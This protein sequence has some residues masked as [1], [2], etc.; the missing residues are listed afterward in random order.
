MSL[1]LDKPYKFGTCRNIKAMAHVGLHEERISCIDWVEQKKSALAQLL[2]LFPSNDTVHALEAIPSHPRPCPILRTPSDKEV[3]R[4]RSELQE[5][6]ETILALVSALG[7]VLSNFK[8]ILAS[9]PV[10]D[11]SETIAEAERALSNAAESGFV[12]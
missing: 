3:L 4:W 5:Q 6:D 9:K 2:D 1:T 11:A 10:R 12:I 7:R 8:Y